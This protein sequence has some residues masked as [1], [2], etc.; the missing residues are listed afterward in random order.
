MA[1]EYQQKINEPT[2]F[3]DEQLQA[4]FEILKSDNYFVKEYNN[5]SQ[6]LRNIAIDINNAIKGE[7]T[8]QFLVN[9]KV[10]NCVGV[11]LIKTLKNKYNYPP[12]GCQ[13]A[14]KEF[15]ESIISQIKAKP[16]KVGNQE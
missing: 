15:N 16:I 1:R 2:E 7:V 10:Q 8:D 12:S 5:N 11:A 13:Q 3:E 9:S 4:F 14:A 6:E